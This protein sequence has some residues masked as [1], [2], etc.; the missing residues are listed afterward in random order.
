MTEELS[1]FLNSDDAIFH[2]T[3]RDT[4]IKYILDTKKLR[5]NLLIRSA[6]VYSPSVNGC[7]RILGCPI[8]PPAT[9][10]YI[11]SQHW[12]SCMANRY[13]DVKIILLLIL[14]ITIIFI[15]WPINW[16]FVYVCPFFIIIFFIANYMFVITSLPQ[17]F[18]C[19]FICISFKSRNILW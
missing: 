7:Y 15:C 2:Y 14:A 16:I 11:F 10:K 8:G 4:A 1:N 5:L 19:K 3:K 12:V 6:L 17:I 13:I 18:L 9:F